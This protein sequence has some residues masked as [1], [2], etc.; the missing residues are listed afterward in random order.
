[1]QNHKFRPQL[2]TARYK[3]RQRRL[4]QF[5][6]T[7]NFESRI[8]WWPA[9]YKINKMTIAKQFKKL[10]YLACHSPE[11]VRKKWHSVYNLFENKHFANKGKNIS[12]R[13]LNEHTC[14][15]WL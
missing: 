10:H 9:G 3:L 13:Y 15:A 14:H 4:D 2:F 1:M 11:P 8:E 6:S 12:I 7:Y 5:E